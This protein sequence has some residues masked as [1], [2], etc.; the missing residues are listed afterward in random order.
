MFHLF[1]SIL[2]GVLGA[3]PDFS[4]VLLGVLGVIMSFPKLADRI[5]ASSFSR[6][7]IAS[8]C[9]AVALAG[10]IA[11][12][13][14][15]SQETAEMG[16]LITNTNT[17]VTGTNTLIS[18]TNTLTTETSDVLL[19]VPQ[20]AAIS[21]NMDAIEEQMAEAK[22]NPKALA[23]LRLQAEKA[24]R[25]ETCATNR[26]LVSTMNLIT[27]QMRQRAM[28]FTF[29]IKN[30]LDQAS[31]GPISHREVHR[32]EGQDT[33]AK[34]TTDYNNDM[35]ALLVTADYLRQMMLQGRKLTAED[36]NQAVQFK[37][38]LEGDMNSFQVGEALNYLDRLAKK[39]SL[40]TS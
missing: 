25:E 35:R 17:L 14:Q 10:F 21:A 15:R 8:S 32:K 29:R 40:C 28:G 3:L 16:T 1:N 34:L 22:G 9:I 2:S 26:V 18:K 12:S 7:I 31:S 33:A 5:E 27:S 30:I 36:D 4:D 11:R 23:A 19:M 38:A 6:W 24:R 39:T 20:V 13:Y 37:A